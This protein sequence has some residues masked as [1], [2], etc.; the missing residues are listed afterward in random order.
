MVMSSEVDEILYLNRDAV[1][2]ECLGGGAGVSWRRGEESWAARAVGGR[3]DAGVVV[4]A[5]SELRPESRSYQAIARARPG[6]SG[7]PAAIL[8]AMPTNCPHL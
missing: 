7:I 4:A 8:A 5:R 1:K 3:P 6:R 2:A